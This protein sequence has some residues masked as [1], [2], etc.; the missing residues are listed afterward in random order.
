MQ[1]LKHN[2]TDFAAHHNYM[3]SQ[4]TLAARFVERQ[5]AAKTLAAAKLKTIDYFRANRDFLLRKNPTLTSAQIAEQLL[6]HF[7]AV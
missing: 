2:P 5:E 1:S 7:L 3:R 4:Q 6:D